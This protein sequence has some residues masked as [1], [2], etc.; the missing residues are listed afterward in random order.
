MQKIFLDGKLVKGLAQNIINIE[1]A[2]TWPPASSRHK[3]Y[4]TTNTEKTILNINCSGS[5]IPL[6]LSAEKKFR[7]N[8]IPKK[9]ID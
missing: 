1:T 4:L 9:R 6:G 3:D 5:E 8:K 7:N 2:T